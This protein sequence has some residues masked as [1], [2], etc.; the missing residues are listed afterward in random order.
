MWA[1]LPLIVIRAIDEEDAEN[2]EGAHE[3]HH[4]EPIVPIGN[5]LHSVQPYR[6][7]HCEV[8]DTLQTK[9]DKSRGIWGGVIYGTA[10]VLSVN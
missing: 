10:V 8:S 9:C 1:D 3:K 4:T 7:T 6:T 5:L 2:A